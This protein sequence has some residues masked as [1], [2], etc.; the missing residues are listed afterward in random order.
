MGSTK[1]TYHKERSFATNYIFLENFICV[2]DPLINSWFNAPNTKI[3]IL[4]KWSTTQIILGI[5]H[6]VRKQ[7]FQKTN[8]S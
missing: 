7:N 6:L 2:L 8:I 1:W 4:S 5:I 3:S